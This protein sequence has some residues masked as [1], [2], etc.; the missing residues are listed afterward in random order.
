M[1]VSCP[2]I[3]KLPEGFQQSIFKGQVREGRGWLVQ[4]LVP[5]S[6]VLAAVRVGLVTVFP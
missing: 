6:F 2:K 3:P 1:G 4:F 5:E